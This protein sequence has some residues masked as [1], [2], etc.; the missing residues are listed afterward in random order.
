MMIG[1]EPIIKTDLIEVSL[2]IV[3]FEVV[4]KITPLRSVC[5]FSVLFSKKSPAYLGIIFCLSSPPG[6]SP[7]KRGA[8]TLMIPLSVL[9]SLSFGE[10]WDE[11]GIKKGV[12]YN[13]NTFIM[14]YS[15]IISYVLV[16]KIQ[17][18]YASL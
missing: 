7:K 17:S 16:H 10:G 18:A 8:W 5:K 6:P 2:G 3:F 1:P 12:T 14:L 11:E 15:N 13:S 9:V 4:L